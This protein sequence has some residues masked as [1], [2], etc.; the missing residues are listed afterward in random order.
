MT[1]LVDVNNIKLGSGIG[2]NHV[3]AAAEAD[4]GKPASPIP[5]VAVKTLVVDVGKT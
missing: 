2:G 5:S 3:A 4:A 1:Y